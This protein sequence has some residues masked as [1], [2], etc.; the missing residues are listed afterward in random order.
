MA[1][2]PGKL[3]QHQEE[4]AASSISMIKKTTTGALPTIAIS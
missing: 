4:W 2:S 3:G 1:A